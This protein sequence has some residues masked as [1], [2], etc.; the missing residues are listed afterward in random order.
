MYLA[1]GYWT[2]GVSRV[3]CFPTLVAPVFV[4]YTSDTPES[5]FQAS[6]HYQWPYVH[7]HTTYTYAYAQI[8][9]KKLCQEIGNLSQG[10]TLCKEVGTRLFL[11]MPRDRK[12]DN[13]H[14]LKQRKVCQ[15]TLN[16]CVCDRAM[17]DC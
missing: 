1:D 7:Y 10:R 8:R 12:V 13:R 9:G 11:A 2:H 15:E 3:T 16:Y 4:P 17:V 6:C 5:G 14:Q